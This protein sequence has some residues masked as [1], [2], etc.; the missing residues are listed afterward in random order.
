MSRR[1]SAFGCDRRMAAE[2]AATSACAP[3]SSV[4]RLKTP[5]GVYRD[6]TIFDARVGLMWQYPLVTLCVLLSA[7]V[8]L[9]NMI[10]VVEIT[11]TWLSR[12][13]SCIFLIQ[14]VSV[15]VMSRLSF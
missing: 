4:G 13:E 1:V 5:L 14:N 3:A 9:K 7:D 8:N 2:R 12:F 10:S 6:G 11:H 15:H